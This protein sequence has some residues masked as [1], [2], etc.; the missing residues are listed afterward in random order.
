MYVLTIHS[1]ISLRVHNTM[2]TLHIHFLYAFWH[3]QSFKESK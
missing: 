1:Q 3:N 2:F